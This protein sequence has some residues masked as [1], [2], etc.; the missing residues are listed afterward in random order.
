M[1]AVTAAPFFVSPALQVLPVLPTATQ[2]HLDS[3]Q[4]SGS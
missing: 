3:K 2:P 1:T 4:Y